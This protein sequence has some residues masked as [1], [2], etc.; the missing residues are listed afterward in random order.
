M[1][2][3]PPARPAPIPP[4]SWWASVRAATP[5]TSR[6]ALS[7]PITGK[8]QDTCEY[9]IDLSSTSNVFK[10][11]YRIRL[12][13]SSSNFP[14]FSRNPNTGRPIG[15]ETELHTAYVMLPIIPRE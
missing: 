5:A 15:T 6:T 8:K 3:P 7:A 14:R 10:T 12:E 11:G 1:C 13:I 2:G 4:P 9:V